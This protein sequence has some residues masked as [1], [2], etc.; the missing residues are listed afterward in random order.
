MNSAN[1]F[2]IKEVQAFKKN[3]IFNWPSGWLNTR[4]LVMILLHILTYAAKLIVTIK[5]VAYLLLKSLV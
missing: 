1:Q 2:K 4:S 3:N 5:I